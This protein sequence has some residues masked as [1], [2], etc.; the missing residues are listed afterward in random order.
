MNWKIL[1]AIL[2]ATILVLLVTSDFGGSLGEVAT[3]ENNRVSSQNYDVTYSFDLYYGHFK[4]LHNLHMSVPTSLYNYYQRKSHVLGGDGYYAKFATPGVFKIVA[5]NIKKATEKAPHSDEQFANA[6]LTMVRQI[7]Y[8]KSVSKYPVETIVEN[9]GD[10]DVLSLLAASIM[11]AGGLDVVLL[12][13]KNLSPSHMNLGVYLPQEPVYRSWWVEPSGFEYNN[14]TY[15]IAECTS[16]GEWK[17]GDKPGLLADSKPIVIP[18]GE[19]E[20]SYPTQI[21]CSLDVPL[22]SSTISVSISPENSSIT[23]NDRLLTVTGEISPALEGKSVTMY[24][25]REGL[26]F[27]TYKTFTD[28]QGR[29]SFNWNFT[30]AGKYVMKTSWG[31]T[32]DYAGADSENL[33]VFAG[34]YEPIL[35][36]YYIN[37]ALQEPMAP[38][39]SVPFWIPANKSP[40]YVLRSNVSGTGLLLSGEFIIL[41]EY[42]SG[43]PVVKVRIP[44]I[45]KIIYSPRQRSVM[46]VVV[47]EEQVIDQPIENKQLGFILRQDGEEEY[48]ASVTVLEDQQ[49]FEIAKES[50]TTYINVSDIAARNKWYRVEATIS[51][52]ATNAE[53]YTMNNSLLDRIAAPET[54]NSAE[55]GILMTYPPNSILAFRNLKVSTFDEEVQS[56]TGKQ[57]QYQKSE[58]EWLGLCVMVST[59]LTIGLVAFLYAKRQRKRLRIDSTS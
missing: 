57:E 3:D 16:L 15:W 58:F 17:V 27:E 35:E 20:K 33:T 2:L 31:G 43:T 37:G 56:S 28:E 5:E 50:S 22:S 32:I 53:L 38:A 55:V 18:L 54:L 34:V 11:M 21:S 6:V 4:S 1:R 25:G 12:H 7:P 14:K 51:R 19:N 24:I 49:T 47:N 30:Q 36:E 29:Y 41:C 39:N 46:R 59:F 52:D 10:C 44:K 8:T 40:K 9:S 23:G 48:S 45:E 13:Y 42:D 26:A